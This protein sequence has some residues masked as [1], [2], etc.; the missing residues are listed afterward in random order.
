MS[1][2][3]EETT[4]KL[5]LNRLHLRETSACLTKTNLAELA[6]FFN[7][8]VNLMANEMFYTPEMFART[9]SISSIFYADNM[10]G[11]YTTLM[12]LLA[13]QKLWQDKQKWIDSVDFVVRKR[14]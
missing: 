14:L 2:F 12:S 3:L 5:F 10:N 6:D 8:L 13:K 11:G 7:C 1:M 4:R 9:L